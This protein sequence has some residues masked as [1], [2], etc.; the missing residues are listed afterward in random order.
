MTFDLHNG[1]NACVSV[2]VLEQ[3][4]FIPARMSASSM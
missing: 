1:F 4:E 2:H 3:G